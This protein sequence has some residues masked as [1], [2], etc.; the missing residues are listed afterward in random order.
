M[1]HA[2][3]RPSVAIG[4]ILFA[5]G[6][7]L[8]AGESLYWY[9]SQH[10][11]LGQESAV[12]QVG[13]F[14]GFV[15]L[16]IGVAVAGAVFLGRGL[17]GSAGGPPGSV[18]TVISEALS[19]RADVRVGAVGGAIYGLLYLL[20]SSIL[21]YQPSVDFAQY[22]VTGPS[23]AAATCCGPPGT[24]PEL[25]V[26]LV[27][28]WHIALQILPLDALFAVVIPMLVGLNL[29]VAAH[30]LRNR[31]LRS[32]VGWLGTVGLTAGLF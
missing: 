14:Y 12:A 5:G 13:S 18:W 7:A 9:A 3:S 24:V 28:Q 26:Y 6:C 21:V 10:Y 19:S 15:A 17:A 25:I 2:L 4:A 1:K 29:A 11:V 30:A 23:V 32:N 16:A 31:T 8:V 27:P 22:G 20:V